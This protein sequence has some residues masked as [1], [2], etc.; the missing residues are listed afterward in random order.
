MGITKTITWGDVEKY[1][2]FRQASRKLMSRLT[3]TIPRAAMEEIGNALGIMR[4][5]VLVYDTEDVMAVHA[6]CCLHDWIRNGRNLITKYS[7][8]HPASPGTDEEF[9]LRAHQ[10]ARFRILIPGSVAPGAGVECADGLSGERL[11]LMDVALGNS[12]QEGRTLMATRTVPL[13]GYWMTTGAGLP[14]GDKKT[15]EE[16]VGEVRGLLKVVPPVDPH[17]LALAILRKCLDCGAAEYVTYRGLKESEDSEEPETD[18]TPA[19]QPATSRRVAGRND[20][21]PCGS[22]RKYKRCCLRKSGR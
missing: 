7:L 12:V 10:Q 5:G 3:K 13:D 6:D 16:V 21:C 14:I 4:K 8:E 9:L 17:K 19:P 11:F 15:G 18:F 2:R 22:G 1:Q 20:Q